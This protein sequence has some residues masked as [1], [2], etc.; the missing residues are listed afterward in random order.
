[1]LIYSAFPRGRA[2]LA[3]VGIGNLSF[4]FALGSGAVLG[5]LLLVLWTYA[6]A[7]ALMKW[8]NAKNA[9]L[10]CGLGA[11]VTGLFASKALGFSP[12]APTHPA[13]AFTFSFAIFPLIAF[14]VE[15]YR[16]MAPKGFWPY[17]VSASFF[18][19][20]LSGPVARIQEIADQLAFPRSRRGNLEESVSLLTLGMLKKV[21]IADRITVLAENLLGMAREGSNLAYVVFFVT[22]MLRFYFDFSGY[23]D[24]ARG[25][26]RLL[27][28]ELP[29][30]FHRPFLAVNPIDFW[31]RWHVS[32][33]NFFRNVVFYPAFFRTKNIYFSAALAFLLNGIWHDLSWNFFFLGCYWALWIC[34]YIFFQKAWETWL[35]LFV[36]WALS[37]LIIYFSFFFFYPA[38]AKELILAMKEGRFFATSSLWSSDWLDLRN[39]AGILIGLAFYLFHLL[40]VRQRRGRLK[41]VSLYFIWVLIVVIGAQSPSAPFVYS[42]F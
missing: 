17:V 42:L 9:W 18:P 41:Y 25:I 10:F 40:Y 8:P 38:E 22:V 35:P 37:M 6:V 30:N 2:R 34:L 36:Q 19:I 39:L 5:V 27:G 23:T 3:L 13:L 14:L 29:E 16:G 24:I 21:V 4:L 11:L 1:M 28:V 26:A 7:M 15:V 20:L 31:R 33:A 32:L 12:I